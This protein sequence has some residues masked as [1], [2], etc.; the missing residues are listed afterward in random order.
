M[1]LVCLSL[2]L[3]C[4]VLMGYKQ[5]QIQIL[6]LNVP[7]HFYILTLITTEWHVLATGFN[8]SNHGIIKVIWKLV[9]SCALIYSK[10]IYSCRRKA[11]STQ[12]C[13]HVSNAFVCWGF[14]TQLIQV[15]PKSKFPAL[16]L[17]HKCNVKRLQ[18]MFMCHVQVQTAGRRSSGSQREN[19]TSERH[20]VLSAEEG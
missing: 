20:G 5:R 7:F 16:F 8:E 18:I 12:S 17:Q 15:L 19:K 4:E 14:L 9:I 2:T 3:I 1:W 10:L 13:S 11:N 6:L